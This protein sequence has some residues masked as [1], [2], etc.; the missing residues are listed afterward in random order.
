MIV[1]YC[2]QNARQSGYHSKSEDSDPSFSEPLPNLGPRFVLLV[3]LDRCPW[4]CA[5][6]RSGVTLV[7]DRI[8]DRLME[9]KSL[10]Q[11]CR[12]VVALVRPA[13]IRSIMVSC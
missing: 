6:A 11:I 4:S 8:C 9:G 5:P 10:R 3:L 12:S 13:R 7:A 1:A 2:T